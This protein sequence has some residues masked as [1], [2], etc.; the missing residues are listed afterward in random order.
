MTAEAAPAGA[1][2]TAAS[3]ESELLSRDLAMQA[4]A[5]KYDLDVKTD[6]MRSTRQLVR[7]FFHLLK[8]VEIDLFVEAGA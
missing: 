4:T 1:E 3:K 5:V 6:R 8:L 7:L 2:A